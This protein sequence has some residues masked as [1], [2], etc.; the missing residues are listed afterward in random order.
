MSAKFF[1]YLF[2]TPFVIWAMD[3][4]NINQILKKNKV[5]QAR[6]FCI[7]LGISLI[8]LTTNFIYDVFLS[9]KIF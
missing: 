5:Y 8:Y 2:T 9:S 4:I 7:L 1:V 6:V 3:S